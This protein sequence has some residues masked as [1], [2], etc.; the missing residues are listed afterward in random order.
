MVPSHHLSL[1]GAQPL[2]FDS[3][4]QNT[5][6]TINCLEFL[7]PEVN[8]MLFIL[9]CHVCLDLVMEIENHDNR[10]ISGEVVIGSLSDDKLK[11]CK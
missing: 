10:I 2:L 9:P 6:R 5:E 7:H 1:S 11:I 4:I 3:K 8:V